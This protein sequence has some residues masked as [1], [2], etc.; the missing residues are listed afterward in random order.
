ME[1]GQVI[2]TAPEE[3]KIF[4]RDMVHD[5]SQNDIGGDVF[6]NKRPELI[7]WDKL[8]GSKGNSSV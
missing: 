3:Y 4:H 1:V 7:H 8:L 6:P 2:L 5:N